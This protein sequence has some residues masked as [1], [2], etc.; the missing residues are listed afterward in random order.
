M[1]VA[2]GPRSTEP[3][4]ELLRFRAVPAGTDAAVLELE[5]RFAA[6]AQRRLGRPRLLVDNEDG[7]A[8]AV[9]I[10][11]QEAFAGPDAAVWRAT[12]ALPL[13]A[14]D[15][16]FTIAVGRRLALT[17]PAPYIETAQG[18]PAAHHVRLAREVN[19]LR[20][21]ADEAEAQ[22]GAT[23]ARADELDERLKEAR[24][25]AEGLRGELATALEAARIADRTME[26]EREQAAT[27]AAEAERE[28]ET[29]RARTREAVEHGSRELEAQRERARRAEAEAA[30]ELEAERQRGDTAAAKAVEELEAKRLVANRAIDRVRHDA[31]MRDQQ[32]QQEHTRRLEATR[33]EHEEAM[34]RASEESLQRLEEAV[35]A[36]RAQ[37]LAARHDLKTAR[38]ELEAIF[39]E[40]PEMRAR[41]PQRPDT[42]RD[43]VAIREEPPSSDEARGAPTAT[44]AVTAS[45]APAPR[46]A[47]TTTS[48]HA[49][50][51]DSDDLE[52]STDEVARA[53][54]E[55]ERRRARTTAGDGADAGAQRPDPTTRP[56][57]LELA[58]DATA[59]TET[60]RVLN[61]RTRRPRRDL[62]AEAREANE[63]RTLPGAAE[64]G[65]QHI[66]P[67]TDR[68][69]LTARAAGASGQTLAIA[70]L[71]LFALALF[72]IVL[73]VG[74]F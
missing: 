67:A 6:S 60:V 72:V 35:A 61:P 5:G 2:T 15:G 71:C 49:L 58:A 46:E 66:A 4:L 22:A 8:E 41:R 16:T 10:S 12:Y 70:A 26:G 73:G 31:E 56:I 38:A 39:R 32:T 51:L 19:G 11:G 37:A 47:T 20:R 29:Q 14:V 59:A 69:D 57:A 64:I 23:R 1:S 54:L 74:P 24:E 62:A 55:E 50:E 44:T 33:R 43:E 18:A 28:L 7:R 27:A 53:H 65:A 52:P 48:E 17:L 36:Q 13:A 40:H 42:A 34:A 9:A 21:R 3:A 45:K 25:Q 68:R 63:S 30:R